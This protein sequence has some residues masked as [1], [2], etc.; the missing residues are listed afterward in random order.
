MAILGVGVDVVHLPR[1]LAL[2]QRRGAEALASRILSPPEMQEW[3]AKRASDVSVHARFLAVRWSLKEAAYKA[4]YPADRPT[5]KEFAV[6][7]LNHA[8]PVLVY[9]PKGVSTAAQASFHCSVSHDGDYVFSTVI[10]EQT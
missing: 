6:S 5:W 7:R 9:T 1:I 4:L 2:V 10:A 3:Q 8:K